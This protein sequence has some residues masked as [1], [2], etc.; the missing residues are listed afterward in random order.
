MAQSG[1]SYTQRVFDTL[2]SN[3]QPSRHEKQMCEDI[4]AFLDVPLDYL[5]TQ[6]KPT[7]LEEQ[8]QLDRYMEFHEE[9]E[10]KKDNA[11]KKRERGTNQLE[12]IPPS[13]S[14]LVM[15]LDRKVGISEYPLDKDI[16]RIIRTALRKELPEVVVKRITAGAISL[17]SDED[18]SRSPELNNTIIQ[19]ISGIVSSK[20]GILPDTLTPKALALLAHSLEVNPASLILRGSPEQSVA[21]EFEDAL[22]LSD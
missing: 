14:I 18:S 9:R 22:A 10:S 3:K 7:Q 4:A 8:E 19:L 17:F 5:F 6:K 1:N 12:S 21:I 13:P 16:V 20:E 2:H 15:E 11:P